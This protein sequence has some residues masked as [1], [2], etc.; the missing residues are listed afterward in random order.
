MQATRQ[1]FNFRDTIFEA[2]PL[3]VSESFLDN[4]AKIY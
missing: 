2:V 4:K 1:A 3:N